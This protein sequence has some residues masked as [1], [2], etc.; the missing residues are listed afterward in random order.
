MIYPYSR[1]CISLVLIITWSLPYSSAH[2]SVSN[3]T[4]YLSSH[5]QTPW[6]VMALSVTGEEPDTTFLQTV[7]GTSAID[8]EAPILALTA[9]RLDPRTYPSH[10]LV[11]S[12]QG[13]FSQGQIGDPGTLNDDIFGILALISAGVQPSEVIVAETRAFIEAHQNSD[14]GWSFTTDGSSD[15]NTTAAAVMALIA[16][17]STPSDSKIIQALDYLHTAQNQDGGFPYDPKSQ[18]GTASDP[19]S[20]AWVLLALAASG[21]DQSSWSMASGTPMTDLLSYQTPDGYFEFQHGSGEDSFT[22]I[23]TSYAVLALSGKTLP[24]AIMQPVD[25]QEPTPPPTP[26]PL[27]SVSSGGG[28]AISGPLSIGFILGTTTQSLATTTIG[29]V[30]GTS[31]E[32]V[33]TTTAQVAS[34]TKDTSETLLKY[35]LYY[36]MQ[37]PAVFELQRKLITYGRLS[38]IAPTGWFGPRTLKAVKIFQEENEI[39]TTGLVGPMTRRSLSYVQ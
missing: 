29:I 10:D 6:A 5:A 8:L 23:T 7:S 20:D 31:T 2:A 21:V 38:I 39:P 22:P 3:A 25:P 13:H 32:T 12:L 15:T 19:S 4:S 36:G 35:D 33:A 17:G 18:W 14:G 26:S 9:A 28:G 34:T 27:P 37:D 16:S 24:V 1:V 11:E 30:F